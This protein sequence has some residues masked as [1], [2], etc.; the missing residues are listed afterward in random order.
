MQDFTAGGFA[1]GKADALLGFVEAVAEV[2]VGPA[3]GGNNGLIHLDVQI[4]KRSNVCGS[5]VGIMEA[6][7]GL[8]KPFSA[9]L[10]DRLSLSEI[11][12]STSG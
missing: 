2:Q 10:R 6:V 11:S 9:N 3:V 1:D 5:L 12:N 7:V 8:G 4:T